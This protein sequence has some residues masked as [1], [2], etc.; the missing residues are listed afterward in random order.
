MCFTC[1]F[2][3]QDKPV[4]L[5]VGTCTTAHILQ[6]QKQ[7]HRLNGSLKVSQVVGNRDEIQAHAAGLQSS[8][9]RCSTKPPVRKW[10]SLIA[11]VMRASSVAWSMGATPTKDNFRVWGQ[12]GEN[13]AKD[14]A[15]R[16]Q[17]VKGQ[18]VVTHTLYPP[19]LPSSCSPSTPPSV[20]KASAAPPASIQESQ[21]F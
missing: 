16:L 21:C 7:K 12:E 9:L 20:L 2:H 15:S 14:I 17:S 11:T 8:A 13:W 4:A 6:R 19:S 1:S 3:P 18:T 5:Q 10:L